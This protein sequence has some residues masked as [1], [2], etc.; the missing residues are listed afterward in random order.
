MDLVCA[1]AKNDTTQAVTLQQARVYLNVKG[2]QKATQTIPQDP[3]QGT[4]WRYAK[5]NVKQL[6]EKKK[7]NLS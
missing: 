4:W 3:G 6:R 5:T 2:V 7:A 1:G